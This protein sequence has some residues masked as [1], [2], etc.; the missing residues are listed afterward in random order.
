MADLSFVRVLPLFWE[1]H[2]S[3]RFENLFA[4]EYSWVQRSLTQ[5]EE[6]PRR[7]T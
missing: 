2:L 3:V 5:R 4:I 1:V 6:N 7:E